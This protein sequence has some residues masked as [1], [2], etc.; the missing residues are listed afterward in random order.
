MPVG[1]RKAPE[2]PADP[3]L[4][5]YWE[6]LLDPAKTSIKEFIELYKVPVKDRRKLGD[7]K[8]NL[9]DFREYPLQRMQREAIEAAWAADRGARICSGKGRQEG[10]TKDALLLVWERFMRGD[11][12]VANIFSYD[13]D[14]TKESLRFLHSLRAQTPA[15]V[16]NCLLRGGGGEWRR[17]S[18]L[19]MEIAWPDGVNT[20]IQCLTAGDKSSGSGSD[21]RWLLFDEFPKWKPEIKGDASS[22]SEGWQEGPGNFWIIQG[23]GMGNEQYAEFF[24]SIWNGEDDS[25]F[26]AIFPPRGWLGHPSRREEFGSAEAKAKFVETIG[27]A[28]AYGIKDELALV[29]AGAEPEEILWRRRKVSGPVIRWNLQLARREY[30]LVPSDMF[31][32]SSRT[33]F[34]G[35]M[36]ILKSHERPSKERPSRTGELVED[37][38]GNLA[39]IETPH[40]PLTVWAEPEPGVDYAF[41]C[42]PSSGKTKLAASNKEPDFTVVSVGPVLAEPSP[43]VARLRG[44]LTALVAA[45]ELFKLCRWYGG[46]RGLVERNVGEALIALMSQ[47][48]SGEHSGE[49]FL[50]KQDTVVLSD[51]RAPEPQVGYLTSVRT[52]ELVV[53]AVEGVLMEVGEWRPGEP[54]P[55]DPL[56]VQE[57]ISFERSPKTGRP[58]AARGH[59]DS[60]FAE[61]MREIARKKLIADGLVSISSKPRAKRAEGD[62]LKAALK[63]QRDDAVKGKKMAVSPLGRAF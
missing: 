48:E 1:R 56:F 7:R 10:M 40:G 2:L 20:M 41:G 60:I 62:P 6:R 16:F 27:K 21:P 8:G 57:C 13:T 51:G 26:V 42:D 19:Q 55:L 43:C 50:L 4:V 3:K 23:T 58:E 15:W 18:A 52:R 45:A 12:G 59:D 30:P 22:M 28:Q 37:Q 63:K 11:G 46:A 34:A 47:M 49:D 35:Q 53:A 33:V 36:D 25:G 32:S 38:R 39:F 44:H 61:G 54:S 5:A 24:T 14:A 17:E 31:E 29:A 9:T